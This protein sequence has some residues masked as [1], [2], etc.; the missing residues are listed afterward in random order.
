MATTL[1]VSAMDVVE[2]ESLFSV[3]MGNMA[4]SA[5]AWSQD[6]QTSLG[7]NAYEVRKNVGLFYNMTTSMGLARD[8]AST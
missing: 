7:L 1:K 2:S 6:L 3:S 4:D 5:R 8:Q